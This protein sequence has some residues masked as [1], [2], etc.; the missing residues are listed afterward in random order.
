MGT[1]CSHHATCP[2]LLTGPVPKDAVTPSN[3]PAAEVADP[4]AD[5]ASAEA[6]MKVPA[7]ETHMPSEI[8]AGA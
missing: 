7:Q 2:V 6:E 8:Q 5:V 4:V 3:T 1:Y